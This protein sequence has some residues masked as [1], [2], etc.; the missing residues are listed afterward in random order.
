MLDACSNQKLHAKGAGIVQSPKPMILFFMLI[1]PALDRDR[2]RR[3]TGAH[4]PVDLD[5]FQASE[6]PCHY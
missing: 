1:I 5:E 6:R 2:D 4:R 3:V